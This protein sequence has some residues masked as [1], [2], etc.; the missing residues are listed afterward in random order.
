VPDISDYTR[1]YVVQCTECDDVVFGSGFYD[2]A[3]SFADAHEEA[4]G[5]HTDIVEVVPRG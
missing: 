2:V 5:H 1:G 3:E 4:R